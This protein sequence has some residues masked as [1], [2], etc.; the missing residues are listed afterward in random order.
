MM[1]EERIH[2][3]Q[4][5]LINLELE[6]MVNLKCFYEMMSF[7]LDQRRYNY[8]ELNNV[9]KFIHYCE[10]YTQETQSENQQRFIQAAELIQLIKNVLQ[11]K[12]ILKFELNNVSTLIKT[13]RRQINTQSI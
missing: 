6:K 1:I 2:F 3:F 4:K 11:N 9:L 12:Q 13:K 5:K 7:I 8:K 10:K